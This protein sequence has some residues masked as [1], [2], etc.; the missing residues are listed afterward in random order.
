MIDIYLQTKK[1]HITQNRTLDYKE[2]NDKWVE[3]FVIISDSTL[4]IYRN[5]KE[6]EQK[7]EPSFICP[8]DFAVIHLERKNSIESPS[9][10]IKIE[11]NDKALR[12]RCPVSS[13]QQQ[14]TNT[15]NNNENNHK[16]DSAIWMKLFKRAS[17]NATRKSIKGD[18]L[19]RSIKEFH[20][21]LLKEDIEEE[22]KQSKK[23]LTL[24]GSV[25]SYTNSEVNRIVTN[26]T[27]SDMGTAEQNE[28]DQ[29]SEEER[30]STKASTPALNLQLWEGKL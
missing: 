22:P 27:H 6:F 8:L 20:D 1:K 25:S 3:N 4:A 5:K 13:E 23:R 18:H 21:K 28:N 9:G 19:V 11:S 26:V 7:R 16:N 17:T 14:D 15:G 12:F 10:V 30:A 24:N 2:N 29:K